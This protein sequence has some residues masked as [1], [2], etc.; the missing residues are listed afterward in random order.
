M[1]GDIFLKKMRK[2]S[3]ILVSRTTGWGLDTWISRKRSKRTSRL[4]LRYF[5][6]GI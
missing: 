5:S 6:S 2:T 4:P 3:K 1:E